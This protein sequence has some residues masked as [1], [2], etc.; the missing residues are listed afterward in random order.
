MAIRKIVSRA[1]TD[2]LN[3]DSGT[4]V[5]DDANN[6]VG[7]GTATPSVDL[8][9][10]STSSGTKFNIQ[11]SSSGHN[12]DMTDATGTGRI[13]QVGTILDLGADYTNTGVSDP[14]VRFRVGNSVQCSITG[15]GGIAF[16]NDTSAENTL[17][18]YEEG[19]WTPAF[20]SE[21]GTH[22]MSQAQGR[23]TKIGN[24]VTANFWL[25]WSSI[26]GNGSYGIKIT[27][28]PF[29]SVTQIVSVRDVGEIQGAGFENIP[30][31]STARHLS[32]GYV[33]SNSTEATP[34][35]SGGGVTEIS[36]SG[37]YSTVGGYYYG[38]II[39]F[40]A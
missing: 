40:A 23:Y 25:N 34:R 14:R 8:D 32:G 29:T 4:L 13:R 37:Q 26:S 39:Y 17:D 27:G 16:G 24:L 3:V 36:L 35:F 2:S 11:T 20:S 19:T 38:T 5:V 31:Q 1:L 18:D 21:A 30:I 6:R 7:I 10:Q 12:F 33:N 22:S 28:L 9:I 15:H